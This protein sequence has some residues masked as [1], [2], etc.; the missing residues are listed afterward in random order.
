MD[1]VILAG[2]LKVG[3]ELTDSN[4]SSGFNVIHFF[5]E[6]SSSSLPPHQVSH[7]CGDDASL[8]PPQ[9]IPAILVSAYPRAMLNIHP[10]LL[11]SFGG[12]GMYGEKVHAA[13]VASGARWG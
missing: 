3:I 12:K 2:Y 6:S 4:S 11:P 13:V 5:E 7:P 9:L 1:Y 10:G 8:L